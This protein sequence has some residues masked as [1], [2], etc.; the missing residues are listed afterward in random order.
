MTSHDFIDYERNLIWFAFQTYFSSQNTD[1]VRIEK[2]IG[3][4]QRYDISF[5]IFPPYLFKLSSF[6][7]YRTQ[8]YIREIKISHQW[9]KNN[10]LRILRFVYDTYY[11][12]RLE[13]FHKTEKNPNE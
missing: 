13:N 6:H 11:I 5:Y 1:L 12:F 2:F 4:N 8:K 3:E 7:R 10:V 9:R